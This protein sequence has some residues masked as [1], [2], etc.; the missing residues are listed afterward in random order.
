MKRV[1]NELEREKAGRAEE[2]AAVVVDKAT[3]EEEEY[4]LKKDSYGT[5]TYISAFV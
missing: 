2:Q 4:E 5:F 3:I 1:S